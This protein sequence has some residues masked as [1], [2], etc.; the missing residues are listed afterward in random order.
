NDGFGSI[1]LVD[2]DAAATAEVVA[3]LLERIGGPLGGDVAACLYAGLVTDTGRFQFEATTPE[4]LRLAARLREEPFDHVR[5]SQALYEDASLDYL[6][7]L[8]TLLERIERV[9]EADLL[10]THLSRKDLEAAGI[11][12]QETEDLIDVVRSAR[13]ADVAAVLKEQREGGYKVSLRSKG[14][15]DVSAIAAGFGGGGHRLAAGYSSSLDLR[16]TVDG[17]IGALV[18]ARV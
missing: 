13:E 3:R 4:V 7:L 17:L 14:K 9:P 16:T 15:T 5:L 11:P 12:I 6:R 8:G 18:D 1:N 2:P 10:W